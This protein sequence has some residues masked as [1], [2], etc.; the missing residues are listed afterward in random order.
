[1]RSYTSRIYTVQGITA[2]L[3]AHA[4]RLDVPYTTAFTHI[5]EHHWTVEQALGLA[6]R[7]PAKPHSNRRLQ[8]VLVDGPRMGT[9]SENFLRACFTL[10]SAE[11]YLKLEGV[12]ANGHPLRPVADG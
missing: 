9:P 10:L 11:D 1:M 3:R 8:P 6:P 4:L 2:S 7:P 5:C 12:P